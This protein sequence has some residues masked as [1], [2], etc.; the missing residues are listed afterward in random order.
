MNDGST[1]PEDRL[2]AVADLELVVRSR[3]L[4]DDIMVVRGGTAGAL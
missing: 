3:R 2:G 1:T 4:Q